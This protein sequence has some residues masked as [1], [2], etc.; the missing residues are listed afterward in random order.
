MATSDL[1]PPPQSFNRQKMEEPQTTVSPLLGLI[2]VAYWWLMPDDWLLLY[3]PQMKH[4]WFQQKQLE[5]IGQ[6]VAVH[7]IGKSGWRK[8]QWLLSFVTNGP[9]WVQCTNPIFT[10]KANYLAARWHQLFISIPCCAIQAGYNTILD[11]ILFHYWIWA[12][13]SCSSAMWLSQ[14]VWIQNILACTCTYGVM[15]HIYCTCCIG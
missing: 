12:N 7:S 9:H 8:I 6:C 5:T 1:P 2:S 14:N 13:H 3:Q 11:I 15:D 10:Y 4:L